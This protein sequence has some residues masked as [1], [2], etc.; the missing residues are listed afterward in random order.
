MR[1]Q[2]RD[3]RLLIEEAQSTA[4]RLGHDLVLPEHVALAALRRTP[5]AV[6]LVD[7]D[8]RAAFD[9]QQLEAFLAT[10]VRVFGTPQLDNL[11]SEQLALLDRPA[12]SDTG[13]AT[14]TETGTVEPRPP[15]IEF[16][17]AIAKLVLARR[18]Q[19]DSDA[20]SDAVT[21][22]RPDGYIV[23][24]ESVAEEILT[25]LAMKDRAAPL[26]V[27]PEGAGRTSVATALANRLDE[28]APGTRF[29][30]N[31]VKLVDIDALDRR[32]LIGHLQHIADNLSENEILFIDNLETFA[33]AVDGQ[34]LNVSQLAKL[35]T[36]IDDPE[37]KVV[38]TLASSH[39]EGFARVV[40][41]LFEEVQL[42]Q[43][44]PLSQTALSKI[45]HRHAEELVSYHGTEIDLDL[46]ETAIKPKQFTE[47]IEHPSL[48][49]W[50]LD[51][52]AARASLF[53]KDNAATAYA[54]AGTAKPV[55]DAE[56]VRAAVKAEIQGQDEAI[57]RVVD[58]LRVMRADLD[59]R[60]HRPDG[61]FLLA[62]PTGVG[63]TAFALA[64]AKHVF[65]D[66][67]AIIRLDMSEYS[68]PHTVSKLIGSPPGY[69]GSDEPSQW[70]TTKILDN[71]HR[72]LLL[73]EIEKAHPKIW[74]TFLQV[75]DAGRITDSKG[76]TADFRETIILLTSNMGAESFSTSSIGF[77]EG[78]KSTNPDAD[79]AGVLR[80]IRERMAPE[81]VNRFDDI[82]V[83]KPL[84]PE[85]VKA[86]ATREL[87]KV[88]ERAKKRGY[89]LE[90]DDTALEVLAARGY[91]R[92]YGARPL[93]RLIDA[94]VLSPLSALPVGRYVL[95]EAL[96]TDVEL[97][98]EATAERA[99]TPPSDA[100]RLELVAG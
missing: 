3:L 71:P 12:E 1:T 14:D 23:E 18:A 61:V 49:V 52:A 98:A 94:E 91:S 31:T 100:R 17:Q 21:L 5:Q 25:S 65:D 41:E 64:L 54:T 57:D 15:L 53:G 83:F 28:V 38:L 26:I 99:E 29:A 69:V 88:A 27:A 97:A 93:L 34:H 87:A 51:R 70:L 2:D 60:S 74:Q 7:A 62:G 36:L 78:A 24:R 42:V 9:Q 79:E 68:E 80:A 35:K 95:R 55:F 86:I 48:A 40:P 13:S 11:L 44:P 75:F 39:L 90:I 89:E 6:E 20:H 92:E 58:L 67:D 96:G 10:L 59:A 16:L 56:H 73:D 66:E 32:N 33:D 63:K 82:L 30:G 4:K 46:I 50:R 8:L 37:R 76:A 85:H 22:V 81:L 47:R 45:A 43:L 77:G 72:V 84:A 19:P